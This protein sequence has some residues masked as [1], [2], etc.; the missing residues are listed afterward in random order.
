M[1]SVLIR[2]AISSKGILFC[3]CLV[4]IFCFS[5]LMNS[6]ATQHRLKGRTWK[7]SLNVIYSVTIASIQ[8]GE[9]IDFTKKSGATAYRI[10]FFKCYVICYEIVER[11]LASKLSGMQYG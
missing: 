7:I 3:F 4:A 6:S 11:R 8:V 10:A 5:L 2:E 9:K 1:Q